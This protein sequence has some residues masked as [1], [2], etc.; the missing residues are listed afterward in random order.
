MKGKNPTKSSKW[1]T[2]E[3]HEEVMMIQFYT[4]IKLKDLINY[5]DYVFVALKH[6]DCATKWGSI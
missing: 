5:L 3:V 6:C 1:K 4:R 2:R